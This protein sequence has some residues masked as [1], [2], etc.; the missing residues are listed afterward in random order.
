MLGT[1]LEYYG[2]PTEPGKEKSIII[3]KSTLFPDKAFNQLLACLDMIQENQA[4]IQLT[5]QHLVQRVDELTMAVQQWKSSSE[6]PTSVHDATP[7]SIPTAQE[8]NSLER[9]SIMPTTILTPS[10]IIPSPPSHA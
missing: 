6:K 3:G 2:F 9:E 10:K 4:T 7:L 1:I 5:Q 8:T